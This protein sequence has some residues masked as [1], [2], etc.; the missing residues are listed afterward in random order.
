MIKVGDFLYYY[1]SY[2][3]RLYRYEI[4]RETK[5][6]WVIERDIRIR[7]SNLREVGSYNS[8]RAATPE[9]EREY[10][11]LNNFFETKFTLDKIYEN[12]NHYIPGRLNVEESKKLQEMTE[13]LKKEFDKLLPKERIK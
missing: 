7:K 8:F 3:S 5:T 4:L 2:G 1:T 9:L 12:R 10:M 6:Q 11:T 13:N